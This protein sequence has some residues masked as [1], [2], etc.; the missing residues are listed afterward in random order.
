MSELPQELQTTR[1]LIETNAADIAPEVVKAAI[2]MIP[3]I[4]PLA[5]FAIDQR[6]ARQISRVVT[7]LGHV[8]E[9]LVRQSAD[10][11][12]LRAELDQLQRQWHERPEASAL[13]EAGM[14]ASAEATSD[15]RIERLAKVVAKGL[16]ADEVTAMNAARRVRL[17]RSVDDG[18]FAI[19]LVVVRERRI[20]VPYG[21][22]YGW[23]EDG[24]VSFLST[25]GTK[26]P[27]ALPVELRQWSVA[28]L[29]TALNNLAGLG[30]IGADDARHAEETGATRSYVATPA[31]DGLVKI[32]APGGL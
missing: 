17:L 20:T 28:D 3:V 18:E 8:H 22:N 21:Q 6:P 1:A 26:P 4:G 15:A 16:T 7:F 25:E 2:S 10:Y 29:T 9:V 24:T 30:L 11:G 19:L 12:R 14:F 5:S 23:V 27:P 31:A 13:L 32:V